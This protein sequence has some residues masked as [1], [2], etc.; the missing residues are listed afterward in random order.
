MIQICS[1][2]TE[3]ITI[4]CLHRERDQTKPVFILEPVLNVAQLRQNLVDLHVSYS[5][6][7]SERVFELALSVPS[8]RVT[9]Y[10]DLARA[11]GG[12]SMAARSI[13]SIL[14]KYPN[15]RAIPFHRI[16]YAGGKVW[17]TDEHKAKRQKLF[18]AEGI[19]VNEKG[20]IKDFE[21]IRFDFSELN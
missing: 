11:A 4:E 5:M 21:E 14:S 13:T 3:R 6:T 18:K 8:G 10:G 16:V 20:Y 15:K 19:E 2:S 7:F 1:Q 12:G 17:W 9:T